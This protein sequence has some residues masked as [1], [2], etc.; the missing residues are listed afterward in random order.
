MYITDLHSNNKIVHS[1]PAPQTT[2]KLPKSKGLGSFLL[3]IFT[4]KHN[5]TERI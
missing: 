2:K 3:L 5:V 1:P 4:M